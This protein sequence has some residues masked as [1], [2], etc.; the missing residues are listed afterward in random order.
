[1][2]VS[3]HESPPLSRSSFFLNDRL[4]EEDGGKYVHTTKTY[5]VSSYYCLE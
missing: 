1:M 5:R 3:G 4:D 2:V